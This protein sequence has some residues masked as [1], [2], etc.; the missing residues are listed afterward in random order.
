MKEEKAA[1]IIQKIFRDFNE[2]KRNKAA[3]KI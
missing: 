2:R 3:R 1:K